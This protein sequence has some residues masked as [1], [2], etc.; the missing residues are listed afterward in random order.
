MTSI[1]PAGKPPMQR[2][3]LDALTVFCADQRYQ[4]DPAAWLRRGAWQG[5]AVAV[6]AQYLAMTSWYGYDAELHLI[7]E[8]ICPGISGLDT[9]NREMRTMGMDLAQFS[10][11]TRCTHPA[12]QHLPAGNAGSAAAA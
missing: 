10:V 3:T 8:E 4:F 7:A 2:Q 6:V 9:F 5:N 12:M 1:T 11:R